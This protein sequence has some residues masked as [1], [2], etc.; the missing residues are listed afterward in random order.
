VELHFDT[1]LKQKAFEH[2]HVQQASGYRIVKNEPARTFHNRVY[3][4]TCGCPLK[5]LPESVW[6]A[7]SILEEVALEVELD[8]DPFGLTASMHFPTAF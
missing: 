6:E 3:D 5:V 4:E 7:D 2:F 1:L 8:A